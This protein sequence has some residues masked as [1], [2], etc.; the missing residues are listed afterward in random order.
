MSR[1]REHANAYTSALLVSTM[2]AVLVLVL[3]SLLITAPDAAGS[4]ALALLAL[5]FAALAQLEMRGVARASRIAVP[6]TRGE[7][8]PVLPGRVTDTVHH[9][10][11]P[12]APGLT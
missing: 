9:P 12:R 8:A 10:L 11:R 2:G 6:A 5:A 7:P 1:L 4:V 3:P